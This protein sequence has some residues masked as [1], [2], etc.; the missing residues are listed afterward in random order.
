MI[1]LIAGALL[2]LLA[3]VVVHRVATCPLLRTLAI[4]ANCWAESETARNNAA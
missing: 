1:G 4:S 2:L 3:V